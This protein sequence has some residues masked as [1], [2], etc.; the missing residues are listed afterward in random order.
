MLN[1]SYTTIDDLNNNVKDSQ[2]SK[3][4]NNEES[5]YLTHEEEKVWIAMESIKNSSSSII[6]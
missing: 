6:K 2:T 3:P 4:L 1:N 5:E